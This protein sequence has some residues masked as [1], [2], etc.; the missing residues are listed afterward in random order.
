MGITEKQLS[1]IVLCNIYYIIIFAYRVA[2]AIVEQE[3]VQLDW[4]DKT[5]LH[6]F[7]LMCAVHL[8]YICT[9]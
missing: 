2:A 5:L 7:F 9:L 4:P 8:L 3:G 6:I 1:I